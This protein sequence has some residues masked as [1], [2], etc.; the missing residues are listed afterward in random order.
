M[1]CGR[2]PHTGAGEKSE[3]ETAA[4]TIVNRFPIHPVPLRV[5]KMWGMRT[6]V[7]TSKEGHEKKLFFVLFH[8][9]VLNF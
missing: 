9:T 8:T 4:L 2:D 6:E 3:E 5:G 1:S 7:K